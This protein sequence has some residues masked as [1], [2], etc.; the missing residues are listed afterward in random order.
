MYDDGLQRFALI[1]VISPISSGE[2]NYGACYDNSD[3]YRRLTKVPIENLVSLG[4]EIASINKNF[5][6]VLNVSWRR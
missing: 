3:H 6:S 1:E 5:P 2:L 4:V